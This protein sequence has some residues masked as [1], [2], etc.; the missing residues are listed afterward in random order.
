MCKN[1]KFVK[2][3]V[4][5]FSLQKLKVSTY[6]AKNLKILCFEVKFVNK[7]LFD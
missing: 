7:V 2:F 3:T 5:K 6:K 4:T 1:S